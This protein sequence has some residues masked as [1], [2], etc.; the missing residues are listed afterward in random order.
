MSPQKAV[1]V[2]AKAWTILKTALFPTHPAD[3]VLVEKITKFVLG[4][5]FVT[6]LDLVYAIIQGTGMGLRHSIPIANAY[7]SFLISDFLAA[8]PEYKPTLQR[9]TTKE[10]FRANPG[11]IIT[12]LQIEP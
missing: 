11:I 12:G 3:A 7:M 2:A 10:Y 8:R 4:N 9:K 5:S 1:K 6:F